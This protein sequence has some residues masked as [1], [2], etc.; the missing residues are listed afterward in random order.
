MKKLFR[1]FELKWNALL[2]PMIVI[3]ALVV[4]TESLYVGIYFK[5]LLGNSLD[6]EFEAFSAFLTRKSSNYSGVFLLIVL[7][8]LVMTALL[9]SLSSDYKY[10]ATL[11]VN[12]DHNWIANV[13]VAFVGSLTFA[14]ICAVAQFAAILAVLASGAVMPDG[15]MP[16][17]ALRNIASECTIAWMASYCINVLALIIK[18][19]LAR[20][21]RVTILSFVALICLTV[22]LFY[23]VPKLVEWLPKLMQLN[24]AATY[25][26]PLGIILSA[27]Y[28]VWS[29]YGEVVR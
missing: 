18:K 11:Q 19:C 23:S 14:L 25:M 24:G 22:V 1:L 16:M 29:H 15:I 26:I 17:Q 5:T 13:L 2:I 7:V 20:L 21:P 6:T 9:L 28:G 27:V 3:G 12:K 8:G 4:S 10:F